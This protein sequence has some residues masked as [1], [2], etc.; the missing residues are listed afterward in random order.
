VIRTGVV[1]RGCDGSVENH[2]CD[3]LVAVPKARDC[4]LGAEELAP[5]E[6]WGRQIA[7]SRPRWVITRTGR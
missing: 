2:D 3:G 4:L 1:R 6:R 5:I 7:A